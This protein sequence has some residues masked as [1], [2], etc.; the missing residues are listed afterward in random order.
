MYFLIFL[1]TL[2]TYF[3]FTELLFFTVG[4][5]TQI[6]I[7]SEF[8]TATLKFVVNWENMAYQN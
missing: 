4:V 3:K 7:I 2:K 1:T 8:S 6:N 5:P